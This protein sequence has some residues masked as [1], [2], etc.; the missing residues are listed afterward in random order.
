MSACP[1]AEQAP[2]PDESAN[3]FYAR[4][5]EA[6]GSLGPAQLPAPY[7]LP[8]AG[9]L[10]GYLCYDQGRRNERIGEHA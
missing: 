4:L 2:L 9:G 6:A 8:Y 5:R 7:E 1:L 3:R 10:L